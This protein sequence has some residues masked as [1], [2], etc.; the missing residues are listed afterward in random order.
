ME[1]IRSVWL[2]TSAGRHGTFCC[3]MDPDEIMRRV[4][5]IIMIKIFF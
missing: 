1:D 4:P 5:G 2:N 3:Q